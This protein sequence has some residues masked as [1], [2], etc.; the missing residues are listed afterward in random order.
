MSPF[1]SIVCPC[2]NR[3]R[4]AVAAVRSVLWQTEADFELLVVDDGSKD[5]TRARLSEIKDPRLKCFFNK[6]NAG[7]HAARNQAIKLARGEWIAFLDSDDLFLPRRF[8]VMRE[9]ILRRPEVGFWFSNAYVYRYGRIIGTL[10]DPARAIPEGRVPGY[11]AVGEE[12]L[13]YVTTVVVVR[14][15]AFEKTGYFRQDLKF[16]EDTELYARMIGGGLEVGV[17]RAPLAVRTLHEGNITLAHQTGLDESLEALRAG[18]A[19]PETTER[20]RRRFISDAAGYF[21]KSGRPETARA[22]LLKELGPGARR[23]ALYA[24]TFVPAAALAAAKSLRRLYLRARHHPAFASAEVNEV[25]R[26]I[27]PLLEA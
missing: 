4:Q 10:F 12:Y 1:F 26:R 13:P 22:L 18:D 7:Q 25:W 3:A 8:E 5:D 6:T 11:Y 24:A 19:P 2:Y 14:R 17:V 20:I 21:L 16:L 9:A 15:S 27:T 23:S